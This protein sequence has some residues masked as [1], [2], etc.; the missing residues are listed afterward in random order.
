[1]KI[2]F[3]SDAVYPWNVGGLETLE[4]TEAQELAKTHEVHFFSLKWPGMK[5]D[6][7]QN[8]I[9]YHTLHDITPERFYRA[10]KKVNKGVSL[11]LIWP[12]SDLLL[13]IR[14]Y[15]VK[16]VPYPPDTNAKN[17]LQ[18]LQLQTHT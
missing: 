5:K 6:F 10:R 2:A 7:R 14:L 16:R 8:N 4:S 11:V 1:M 17:I 18:A 12:F 9:S 13:Q 3:I 15:T